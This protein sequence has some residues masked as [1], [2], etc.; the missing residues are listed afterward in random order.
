MEETAHSQH[1]ANNNCKRAALA[2]ARLGGYSRVDPKAPR[3]KEIRRY[4]SKLLT[5][6]VAAK[7][8]DEDYVDLLTILNTRKEVPRLIWTG[9]MRDQLLDFVSARIHD[10]SETGNPN[11]E[12]VNDFVFDAIKEELIVGDVYVRVYNSQ[13]PKNFER[14]DEF[15]SDLLDYLHE[16]RKGEPD[17]LGI[18]SGKYEPLCKKSFVQM[19]LRALCL[20]LTNTKDLALTVTSP[21]AID[22]LFSF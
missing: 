8:A 19:V 21:T 12:L 16:Q 7:L 1:A 17:E 9:E 2:L 15:C 20:V 3:N 14:A 5:P 13:N 18:I 10:Q 6:P 22:D 4:L 11:L